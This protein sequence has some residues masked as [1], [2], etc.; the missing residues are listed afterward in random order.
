MI[1]FT[2][3]LTNYFKYIT[4]LDPIKGINMK[5]ENKEIS[6]NLLTKQWFRGILNM[7]KR[8]LEDCL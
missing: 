6:K 3:H 2:C 7:S 5:K 4:L 1:Y 8:R